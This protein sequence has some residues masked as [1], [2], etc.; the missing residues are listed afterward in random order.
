MTC[1][2]PCACMCVCVHDCLVNFLCDFL[3]FNNNI[4]RTEKLLWSL[5]TALPTPRQ[6]PQIHWTNLH[7]ASKH[8]QHHTTMRPGDNQ[9]SKGFLQ[10][11]ADHAKNSGHRQSDRRRNHYCTRCA[12]IMLHQAWGNVS[13]CTVAN[14]FRH[15]GF[16]AGTPDI[17]ID[18]DDDTDNDIPLL[19]LFGLAPGVNMTTYASI[20]NDTPTS[21]EATDNN[22]I[23]D[24]ISTRHTQNDR[25]SD[26][27]EKQQP[28]PT[29]QTVESGL[30]ACELLTSVWQCSDNSLEFVWRCTAW[31]TSS[32][33]Q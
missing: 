12:T 18:S 10:K 3:W 15:A 5:T 21:D 29:K 2:R 23:D 30:A 8:Q 27:D 16:V 9:Q 4:Y 31:S 32:C 19:P 13:Q 7:A 33:Q 6:K 14:C 25:D 24:I 17:D 11:T 20:D 26:D 28:Q 22:I 1:H